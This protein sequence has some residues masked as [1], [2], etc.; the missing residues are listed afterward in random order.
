VDDGARG[1]NR[2]APDSVETPA[3]AIRPVPDPLQMAALT[4]VAGALL[5]L[6]AFLNKQ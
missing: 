5:N 1:K 6:D 2:Y 4:A 3:W